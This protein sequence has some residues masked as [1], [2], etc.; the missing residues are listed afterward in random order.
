M[1][2]M[3]FHYIPLITPDNDLEESYNTQTNV[4]LTQYLPDGAKEP[5]IIASSLSCIQIS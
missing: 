3:Y 5:H 2:K 4:F 1:L